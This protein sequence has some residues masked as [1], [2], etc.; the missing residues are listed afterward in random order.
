M[1][2]SQSNSAG[3]ATLCIPRSPFQITSPLPCKSGGRHEAREKTYFC[4]SCIDAN[5]RTVGQGELCFMTSSS[6]CIKCS[7]LRNVWCSGY[8]F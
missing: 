8:L 5:L 4:W 3:I 7:G 6:V 1:G 2:E